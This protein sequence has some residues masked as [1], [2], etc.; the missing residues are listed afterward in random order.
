MSRGPGSAQ[1]HVLESVGYEFVVDM[2]FLY[3]AEHGGLHLFVDGGIPL[4]QVAENYAREQGVD[5]TPS[6]IESIRRAVRNLE[7]K[8]FVR[9]D[10]WWVPTADNN[11]FTGAWRKMLLVGPP[12][13]G[14][15]LPA[16]PWSRPRE[17]T[18]S[19]RD[20][21][22]PF[23]R[24]LAQHYCA[25]CGR[26]IEEDHLDRNREFLE[27][28]TEIHEGLVDVTTSSDLMKEVRKDIRTASRDSRL[29][30]DCWLDRAK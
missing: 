7:R 22:T 4:P 23:A 17:L 12:G 27:S 28:M 21:G 26:L 29:C 6:V 1:Q 15:L 14:P 19:K 10:Y 16:G 5:Y 24:F 13:E 25:A 18:P 9:T 11:D 8:G 2:D 3:Q 20:R 30:R